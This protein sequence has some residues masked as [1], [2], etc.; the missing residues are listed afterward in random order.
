MMGLSDLKDFIEGL[1]VSTS[2]NYES[3]IQAMREISLEINKPLQET[4]KELRSLPYNL[5]EMITSYLLG[6]DYATPWRRNT[7]PSRF[8]V[9]IYHCNPTM[10]TENIRFLHSRVELFDLTDLWL[11]PNGAC[12]LTSVIALQQALPNAWEYR[13]PTSFWVPVPRLL[14]NSPRYNPKLGRLEV[15]DAVNLCYKLGSDVYARY[16]N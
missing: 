5:K 7:L 8:S 12:A 2:A 4:M 15:F 3:S 11:F 6:Y 13:E 14:I 1:P 10:S 16:L 9:P